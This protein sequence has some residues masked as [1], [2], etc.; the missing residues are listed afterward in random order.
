MH[1]FS[2][3]FSKIL[4]RKNTFFLD[5]FLKNHYFH[6]QHIIILSYNFCGPLQEIETIT[7]WK[8]SIRVNV[9]ITNDRMPFQLIRINRNSNFFVRSFDGTFKPRLISTRERRRAI[10]AKVPD[11]SLSPNVLARKSAQ[12]RA[13]TVIIT[14]II[15]IIEPVRVQDETCSLQ[16]A[17]L[18]FHVGTFRL[19][20][21]S[22]TRLK[23]GTPFRSF[24]DS[25]FSSQSRL[26][27]DFI[28]V[29]MLYK[30]IE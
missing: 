10:F 22:E 2:E 30:Q 13:V 29:V 21:V 4:F 19:H 5:K 8:L 12:N 25:F 24:P 11:D 15:I 6:P 3:Q 23:V 9:V 26:T 27:V 14:I 7:K 1:L 18:D 17:G 20:R 16:P 28:A